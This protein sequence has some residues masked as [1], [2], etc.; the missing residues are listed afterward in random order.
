MRHMMRFMDSVNVIYTNPVVLGLG[1]SALI[2]WHVCEQMVNG[3]HAHND[4]HVMSMMA[5]C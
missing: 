3:C 4:I 2:D 1:G 5:K